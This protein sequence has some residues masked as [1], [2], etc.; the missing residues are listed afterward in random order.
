MVA[1]IILQRTTCCFYKMQ[2]AITRA[3][4]HH[5]RFDSHKVA[6]EAVFY[7]NG[8]IKAFAHLWMSV[9][10]AYAEVYV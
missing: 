5:R 3:Y 9:L 7:N 1:G 6:T 8:L 2:P 10:G 4:R